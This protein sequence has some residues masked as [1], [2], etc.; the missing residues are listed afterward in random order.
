MTAMRWVN[1]DIGFSGGNMVQAD[2]GGRLGGLRL[3]TRKM[4]KVANFWDTA[5]AV[6]TL[7]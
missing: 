6:G 7:E 1:V 2:P 4:G 5:N 3:Q